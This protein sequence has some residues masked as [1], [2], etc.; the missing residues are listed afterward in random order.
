MK[1]ETAAVFASWQALVESLVAS[2]VARAE[3]LVAVSTFFEAS[4]S[5]LALFQKARLSASVIF[6]RLPSLT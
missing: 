4:E 1:V 5:T 2:E 6:C 3:M